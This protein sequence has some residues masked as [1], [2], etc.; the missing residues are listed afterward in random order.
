MASLQSVRAACE[1]FDALNRAT[2]R[3]YTTV[4]ATMNGDIKRHQSSPAGICGQLVN[5]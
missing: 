4:V 3:A 2:I 1:P 5:P